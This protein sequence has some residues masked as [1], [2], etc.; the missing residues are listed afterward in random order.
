MCDGMENM[1]DETVLATVRE[2]VKELC[3]LFPVYS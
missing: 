3:A 2:K 1:E